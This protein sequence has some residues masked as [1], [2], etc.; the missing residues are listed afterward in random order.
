MKENQ[1]EPI[2]PGEFQLGSL[3]G[4]RQ[5]FSLIAA[6]CS[7]ADAACL[8]EIRNQKSYKSRAPTWSEFCSQHLGISERHANRLI[9]YLDEFGPEYFELAQLTGVT[10]QAYRA[11]APAVQDRALHYDGQIIALLPENAERLA[12]AVEKLRQRS[13]PAPA[14]PTVPMRIDKI[15]QRLAELTAEIS[16]LSRQERQD[17]AVRMRLGSVLKAAREKWH[18]LELELGRLA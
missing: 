5:A 3:V 17:A 4:R 9:G 15:E 12:E 18:R 2:D 10:V 6:R 16:E 11:I 8:R 1:P 14:Q 13:V 7:A